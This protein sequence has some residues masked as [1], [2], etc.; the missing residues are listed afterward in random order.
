MGKRLRILGF[1]ILLGAGLAGAQCTTGAT[2]VLD[3]WGRTLTSVPLV[4]YD[5]F[6]ANPAV[7]LTVQPPTTV[8]YP[9]TATVTAN[10]VKLY[11]DTASTTSA[12]GP[13]KTLA[14]A[15]CAGKSF[16][17][18][19]WPDPD[20]TTETDTLTV[21]VTG[22]NAVVSTIK[23]PIT[24]DD[25]DVQVDTTWNIVLDYAYDTS[26]FFSRAVNRNVIRRAAD[27]WRY[28]IA[29][30]VV[31]SVVPN[32]DWIF[33][34]SKSGY[35]SSGT[36]QHNA[37][38]F[39]GFLFEVF[40]FR[41]SPERSGSL[42]ASN[43]QQISGVN[44]I[45]RRDAELEIDTIGNYNTLG[46]AYPTY[47]ELDWQN[48]YNF[49]GDVNDMLSIA[50]H[51]MG[52]GLFGS[53]PH[54]KWST[55]KTAGNFTDTAV[56]RY[57]NNA[58]IAI[59]GSDHFNGVVDPLSRKGVFG[60]EYNGLMPNARWIATKFDLL[61]LRA[62]GYQLRSVSA[63]RPIGLTGS[64][65]QGKPGVSYSQSLG[66]TDGVPPYKWSISSGS[67]PP[68][69]TMDAQTGVIS[70]K[71]TTAGAY[72]FTASIIDNNVTDSAATRTVTVNIGS[73][74]KKAFVPLRKAGGRF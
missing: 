65:A 28:F 51:E 32:W 41:N 59:D 8:T 29:G 14:I 7:K 5:G 33:I 24:V 6:M 38:G 66:V 62:I 15:S 4:D 35:A 69:L 53:S 73:H 13:S 11:F 19:I 1:L 39:R 68:G 34:W 54:D 20:G 61:V 42:A 10:N 58:T 23:L 21:S 57:M 25:R 30:P 67:L 70:G 52:H 50:H 36:F 71:P 43:Y 47:T 37:V 26:G 64:P 55:Y 45:F 9:A 74:F 16:Y 63:L 12:S 49:G 40:G 3:K 46:W 31:D 48:T 44:Q 72:T 2:T 18:S 17:I 56:Q 22:A 27:D 60:N